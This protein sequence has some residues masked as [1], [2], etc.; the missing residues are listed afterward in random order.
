MGFP[1]AAAIYIGT[2]I[3]S[4]VL[5]RRSTPR[6][7]VRTEKF[8]LPRTVEGEHLPIVLGIA[9]L[10][11]NFTWVG[12][13][14]RRTRNERTLYYAN[15]IGALCH[16][17]LQTIH[18]VIWD[19]LHLS[20]AP[21]STSLDLFKH[22]GLGVDVFLQGPALS[23]PL[24]HTLG[25]N[26]YLD[27]MINAL[28]WFG[29][30]HT[31]DG[32]GGIAGRLHVHGGGRD[33]APCDLITPWWGEE[34]TPGWP[35]IAYVVFGGVPNPCPPLGE[36]LSDLMWPFKWSTDGN[37]YDGAYAG[38]GGAPP[39]PN[40]EVQFFGDA[41]ASDPP[42]QLTGVGGHG[43]LSPCDLQMF[44]ADAF[45]VFV[46]PPD[47]GSRPSAFTD[48]GPAECPDPER[49]DVRCLPFAGPTGAPPGTMVFANT[50]QTCFGC[51]Q[52]YNHA[53][54]KITCLRPGD[55]VT[56]RLS[57]QRTLTYAYRFPNGVSSLEP[58]E[59]MGFLG[60]VTVGS[61]RT[62]VPSGPSWAFDAAI[63]DPGLYQGAFGGTFEHTFPPIP[64]THEADHGG[65]CYLKLSYGWEWRTPWSEVWVRGIKFTV[66]PGGDASQAYTYMPSIFTAEG[67]FYWGTAAR[68]IAPRILA[69]VIPDAVSGAGILQGANPIDAI[70]AVLT[71]PTWGMGRDPGEINLTNLLAAAT[72]CR[73]EGRQCSGVWSTAQSAEQLLEDLATVAEAIP[74]VHR[75]TGLWEIALLRPDYD[76]SLLPSITPENSAALEITGMP[77][78]LELV[79]E[80]RVTFRRWK[81]SLTGEVFTDYELGPAVA[82]AAYQLPG[83]S[84]SGIVLTQDGN[85][86]DADDYAVS[87]TGV[88]RLD[89]RA[90]SIDFE[91]PEPLLVSF[92]AGQRRAGFEDAVATAFNEAM[93]HALGENRSV[94]IDMP[95]L[96]DDVTAQRFA[97]S[98]LLARSRPL[99][100]LRWSMHRVQPGIHPGSMARV[101]WPALGLEGLPVRILDV[102]EPLE[103]GGPFALEAIEEKYGFLSSALIFHPF[104]ERPPLE[105][106]GDTPASLGTAPL[107]VAAAQITP[108]AVRLQLFGAGADWAFEIARTR[109]PSFYVGDPD[110]FGVDGCSA[111]EAPVHF[112]APAG[113]TTFDDVD[114]PDDGCPVYYFLRHIRDGYTPS[115]WLG[116]IR[117]VIEAGET[118]PDAQA[119][120]LPV[121]ALEEFEDPQ[122]EIGYVNLWFRDPQHRVRRVSY[123]IR[124]PGEEWGNEVL[125][126]IGTG[127][128]DGAHWRNEEG[129]RHATASV[130]L[131]LDDR[132]IDVQW[133][134]EYQG[135]DA[136]VIWTRTTTFPLYLEPVW[137]DDGQ[138][139]TEGG[140]AV[141]ASKLHDVEFTPYVTTDDG[142]IV[143]NDAGT[144]A[145][146]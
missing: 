88:L 99:K 22:S 104:P 16:G 51:T 111:A 105:F 110:E 83:A 122:H 87:S 117:T 62:Y 116:P 119:V 107:P 44:Y 77:H 74:Y 112:T 95:M 90:D 72:V 31:V 42:V 136:A 38:G 138:I 96:M 60:G 126:P 5:F 134:V 29:G 7:R 32:Q 145:L 81:P 13:V 113:S 109:V 124:Q 67:R 141:T 58:G 133:R 84:P 135:A 63:F 35:D 75:E 46:V 23:V 61:S 89:S 64:D 128:F 79:N 19:D 20:A 78:G 137:D 34:W 48:T 131:R 1:W 108:S 8:E 10:S 24:P 4:Q 66:A 118:P 57:W 40:G 14:T 12:N 59:Q 98:Q 50:A 139:V 127:L 25:E 82:G 41:G 49:P 18:D 3:L 52:A 2:T 47:Q 115:A 143:T 144:P 121:L 65:I 6:A 92:T 71:N 17:P 21:A 129:W 97:E 55:V 43:C 15:A 101:T 142:L 106:P 36:E 39:I 9:E 33:Q 94:T 37:P 76:V 132:E 114:A 53:A 86:I 54:H 85:L 91:S 56:V 146:W 93:F 140:E 102:R 73:D 26:G 103:P 68:P 123:R 80:V 125:P 11:P 69:S 30:L 28:G 120:V 100:S 45:G 27:E 70:Y 130:N